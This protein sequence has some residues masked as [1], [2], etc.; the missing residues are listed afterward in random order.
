MGQVG[1]YETNQISI[2]TVIW[3]DGTELGV[4]GG[5]EQTRIVTGVGV[6]GSDQTSTVAAIVADG[7]ELIVGGTG[8]LYCYI[9]RSG[10]V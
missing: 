3:M 7:T 1:V 6:G 4:R 10:W 5:T 8:K 9:D 2:V